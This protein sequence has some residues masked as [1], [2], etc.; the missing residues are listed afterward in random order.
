MHQFRSIAASIAWW[1]LAALF[2]PLTLTTALCSPAAPTAGEPLKSYFVILR[3]S[4]SARLSLL[5]IG[6]VSRTVLTG[7]VLAQKTLIL[8]QQDAVAERLVV[9]GGQVTGRFHRLAA[10]LRIHATASMVEALRAMGEV[11]DVHETPLHQRHTSSSVPFIGAP[12]VWTSLPGT[13]GAGVRVGIVDSGIDY[14]HA[15]FGGNGDASAFSANDPVVVEPGTFPTSKVVGGYDFV[16]TSYNADTPST[17]IPHPDP[18]PLDCAENGHGTH[19]AGIAAGLGVVTNSQPY[20]GPY[21]S[22]LPQSMFAIGPGVAPEAQL[23][24]LKVFG[25]SGSTAAVV[26]ALEWAAD[27]NGDE[28]YSDRLDVVN[29]SLGS[30]FGLDSPGDVEQEAINTLVELGCI[31]VASAGNDGNTSCV[32]SGPSVAQQAISVANSID[33]GSSTAAVEVLSPPESVGLLEAIEG[34]FTLPLTATGPIEAELVQT[35]PADACGILSTPSTLSGRIALIDRG[36]CYFVD[37]VRRAQEAGALAVIMVNNV[38]GPPIAMGGTPEYT[39][40]IPGVM[41]SQTDG[42]KLKAALPSKPR[43]R[44]DAGKVISHPEYADQLDSSSSRGPALPWNRLK[45]DIAAPGHVIASAR[46][47]SGAGL[48]RLTGTSMAAPHV[49]GAAALLRALHPNW[50][51]EDIKAALMNTA[52]ATHDS[53]GN[54]YPESMTGAGRI[55]LAEAARL[56]VTARAKGTDG[57][58]SLSFGALVLAKPITVQK[59]ILLRNH[60]ANAVTLSLTVSN[61]V[62]ETGFNVRPLSNNVTVLPLSSVE[63]LVELTANPS[64]FDRTPDLLTPGI[65]GSQPRFSPIEASGQIWF[66]ATNFSLHLPFFASVRPASEYTA[67][68]ETV[69]VDSSSTLQIP[70]TGTS[71]HPQPLVSVFQLGYTNAIRSDLADY[72]LPAHLRAVGAASDAST[73]AT[74]SEVNVFFAIA[75]HASWSIPSSFQAEFDVEIDTN[76]DGSPDFTLVNSSAGNATAGNLFKGSSANDVY[77]PVLRTESSGTQSTAHYTGWFPP[78]TL[79]TAVF[80]NSVIVLPV[81]ASSLGLSPDASVLSYRV[82]SKGPQQRGTR[83]VDSTPWI[84]FDVAHPVIDASPFGI[85]NTPFL[86]A[87]NLVRMRVDSAAFEANGFS[88]SELPSALLLFHCNAAQRYQ[89]VQLSNTPAPRT[90]LLISLNET[91]APVLCWPSVVGQKFEVQQSSDPAFVTY[92]ALA[93]RIEATPPTNSFVGEALPNRATFYRLLLLPLGQ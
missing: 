79:D 34:A 6:R 80:N 7:S 74:L 35:D 60:S 58:V 85:T 65:I 5:K 86:D 28:D 87:R 67:A 47:G 57:S 68:N 44:L 70:L 1:R 78:G 93:T 23:Y 75:T 20:L 59:T 42:A 12:Q 63:L 56:P 90:G 4:P 11:Q 54:P 69:A 15:D 81:P 33:E 37:K 16:G 62:S 49:T 30:P 89:M 82:T 64:F 41:I 76:L 3:A 27:P 55:Q 2:L 14:L 73:K 48:V 17:S 29:L 21:D 61:T 53:S 46:A 72:L 52:I 26:D 43:V 31:V 92:T 13:T 18:D 91:G 9:L 38:S 24:A 83:W 36:T 66:Q 32:L 39:V 40:S 84:R 25:C 19:V 22:S 50:S 71:A 10:G 88:A 77:M 45:P 8:R 51:P